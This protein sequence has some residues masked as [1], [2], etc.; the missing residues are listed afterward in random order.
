[1]KQRVETIFS[2]TNQ[3]I[4]I[5]ILQNASTPIIDE[6]FFYV[7]GLEKGLFEGSY[8]VLYPD[9]GIDII[10]P[11]LEEE[12]A[13]RA[14][15]PMHVYQDRKEMVTILE[16]LCSSYDT[17]GINGERISY[18]GLLSLQ[19]MFPKAHFVDTST[20]FTKSRLIKDNY[21]LKKIRKACQ[22]A[23]GVMKLIPD[24]LIEEI[25]EY[26]M[27]AEINY[28]LQKLGA[29]K[30]AFETISSF[31]TNTAQPHY[32]HG[33]TRLK[34]GNFALFDFGACFRKYNS[35]TTR[36]FVF[37]TATRKQKEMYDTVKEAQQR[38]FDDIQP[39]NTGAM[40]HSTVSSFIDA[41]QFRG[42]FIHS[43]GHS[44]G[45]AVHDVG[46]GLRP[47]ST[48]KFSE[49]MVFTVEPGI[50]LPKIGGVRIEDDILVTKKGVE[51]L[52]KSDR[53]LV[54]L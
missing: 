5:I 7:T 15:L 46:P 10:L 2:N 38:G 43:T 52:T 42:H 23:D 44:L 29:D 22:I 12:T 16:K 39:G 37:G 41:T 28:Q 51:C 54:E 49:N 26:E 1:V 31:H 11:R 6:N 53:D 30:P 25:S 36:T 20:A 4:D 24:L 45:L 48:L 27:A 47:G 8:A 21:E 19:T 9:G 40:V 14:K 50:Y 35:D 3:D 33:T 32:T 13:H 17:I 18:S 34:K